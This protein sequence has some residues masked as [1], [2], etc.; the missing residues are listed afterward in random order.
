MKQRDLCECRKTL[1]L[2]KL[3]KAT[4]NSVH[5]AFPSR[6]KSPRCI[7]K[8]LKLTKCSSFSS[9]Y[10]VR[11]MSGIDVQ[12]CSASCIIPD[13][14]ISLFLS[15]SLSLSLSLTHTHTHTVS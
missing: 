1:L 10:R 5:K 3:T 4:E 11:D 9:K 15:L 7:G 8:L 12:N 6:F 14:I 2:K 13:K